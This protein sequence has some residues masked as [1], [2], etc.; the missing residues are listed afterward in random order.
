M[1]IAVDIMNVVFGQ[2]AFLSNAI[3]VIISSMKKEKKK[4]DQLTI[5]YSFGSAM[6]GLGFSFECYECLS[7]TNGKNFST[8]LECMITNPNPTMYAI[9]Q[10]LIYFTMLVMSLNCLCIL[11]T[12]KNHGWSKRITV[13]EIFFFFVFPVL[14]VLIA[15]WMSTLLNNGYKIIIEDCYFRTIVTGTFNKLFCVLL[16]TVSFASVFILI[17]ALFKLKQEKCKTMGIHIIKMRRNLRIS[18]QA[19]KVIAYTLTVLSLPTAIDVYYMYTNTPFSEIGDYFWPLQPLGLSVLAIWNQ[20]KLIK[21]KKISPTTSAA[22]SV[23]TA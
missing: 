12:E 9:G 23:K 20:I 21:A 1:T 5:A 13:L 6:V 22:S 7:L 11:S 18:R 17:V 8:K 19:V 14:F 2:L 3:F 4:M 10:T 15:C 16:L